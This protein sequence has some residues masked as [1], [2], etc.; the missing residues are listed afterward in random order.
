MNYS[1]ATTDDFEQNFKR[2]FKKYHSLKSDL[3][4]FVKELKDNPTMG[5][6]LGDSIRKVRLAIASKNKGK[7]GGARIITCNVLIDKTNATIYLLTIYDKG[8]QTNIS[9]RKIEALKR[10]NGL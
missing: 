4:G 1:I 6:N 8:E 5:D 9:V 2:L 10:R 3:K 7:S